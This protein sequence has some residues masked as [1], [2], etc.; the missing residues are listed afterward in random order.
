M[1]GRLKLHTKFPDLFDIIRPV[2]IKVLCLRW[3]A[4]AKH[5]DQI[6]FIRLHRKTVSPVFEKEHLDE[7]IERFCFIFTVCRNKLAYMFNK[8]VF[9]KHRKR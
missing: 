9:L 7:V 8:I 4:V 3:G 5:Q 1:D 6:D 2:Y